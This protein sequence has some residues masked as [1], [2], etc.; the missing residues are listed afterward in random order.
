MRPDKQ[1]VDKILSE[2]IEKKLRFMKQRY[3]E[4]GPKASTL[5]AWRLRKQQAENS[6]HKIR[7]PITNKIT[8]KLRRNTELI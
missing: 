6:I 5:L 1:Q 2:E 8:T 3:Y 4:A 7:D